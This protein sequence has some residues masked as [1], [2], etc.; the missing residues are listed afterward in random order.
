M[1][2]TPKIIVGS[3]AL[4][5][6]AIVNFSPVFAIG[7]QWSI[8]YDDNGGT[9][10]SSCIYHY[11][12]AANNCSD[13]FD[14][15][16]D[17]GDLEIKAGGTYILSDLGNVSITSDGAVSVKTIQA[18]ESTNMTFKNTDKI[19]AELITSDAQ[20][21]FYGANIAA[22]S[23]ITDTDLTVTNSIIAMDTGF[24]DYL[25]AKNITI[26]SGEVN[27]TS[28]NGDGGAIVIKD[29]GSFTISGG[30]LNIS[31]VNWGISGG[32]NNKIY[33]NGG[34]S[35]FTNI[36]VHVAWLNEEVADPEN[37]IHFGTGMGIVEPDAYVFWT[38]ESGYPE[39][40][41]FGDETGIVGTNVT[42]QT[43]ATYRRSHGWVDNDND[44]ETD[45]N[46]ANPN[47]S[48]HT[49]FYV[50]G[51]VAIAVLSFLGKK[52]LARR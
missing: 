42:I 35:K 52:I 20:I 7:D 28:T 49:F 21:T 40:E 22:D 29:N 1:K 5:S 46:V 11:Y 34:V 27:I 44:I 38:K 25:S 4:I 8:A 23:I 3:A 30:A 18:D 26:T 43:G 17:T 37:D 47:T 51:L 36:G 24:A 33:F 10:Q 9:A 41:G 14:F 31:N 19:T 6:S 50:A 32:K 45:S 15:A 48:D 13:K 39:D 16:P 2:I 12:D